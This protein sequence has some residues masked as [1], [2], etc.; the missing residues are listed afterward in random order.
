[1]LTQAHPCATFLPPLIM[2]I[3]GNRK[4]QVMSLIDLSI[5][6]VRSLRIVH[7]TRLVRAACSD[8]VIETEKGEIRLSLFS[9]AAAS[10]G[11]FAQVSSVRFS[12]DAELEVSQ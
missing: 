1:M 6:G 2:V 10:E 5:H 12:T 9:A 3:S 4:Q 8:L 7:P 11:G